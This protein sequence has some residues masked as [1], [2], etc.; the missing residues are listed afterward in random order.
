MA[1][2]SSGVYAIYSKASDLFIGRNPTEDKSLDPKPIVSL[3][4]GVK[5]PRV[6]KECFYLSLNRFRLFT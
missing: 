2:L 4:Q 5:A 1:D 3:A 6:G